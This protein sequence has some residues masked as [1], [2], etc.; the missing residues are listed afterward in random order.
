[1]LKAPFD[2]QKLP[3]SYL[4]PLGSLLDTSLIQL[5]N[6]KNWIKCHRLVALAVT[7]SMEP[8][9]LSLVFHK[10]LF[11]LNATFPRQD[12]G[13]PLLNHWRKC[14]EL[15]SQIQ[16]LLETFSLY[17]DHVAG[18][19]IGEPVLL[20]ELICRCSWYFYEKGHFETALEMVG[21]GFSICAGA[22]KTGFHP[23]YT[24]VFVQD[25]VSHLV[26]VQAAVAREKP[27]LAN[28]LGL[29]QQVCE[30]REKNKLSKPGLD[31]GGDGWILM[32]R[33]NLA[34]SLMTLDRMEEA[35]KILLEILPLLE[36]DDVKHTQDIHLSNAALCFSRLGQ[37]DKATDYINRAIKCVNQRDGADETEALAIC[38]FYLSGIR[39]A[40]NDIP[41]AH[42]HLQR[43]LRIR[44]TLKPHHYYT[45]FTHH[46]MGV[47]E[48][49]SGRHERA[50]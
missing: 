30:I 41:G 38:Y 23:G 4:K 18:D 13:E 48:Q 35:L 37:L 40:K 25:M 5:D 10:L 26:N 31:P 12:H 33:G 36:T 1:V 14:E 45:G 17:R 19:H 7:E 43:C 47:L 49:L 42:Q 16:A 15:A 3:L 24:H 8:R 2:E 32:A 22:L 6:E 20:C 29:A 28:V 46:K 34:V 11:F 50:V 21:K 27:D 44:T 39:E 9:E